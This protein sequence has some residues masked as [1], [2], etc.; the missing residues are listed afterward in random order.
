MTLYKWSKIR[1][2]SPT[3]RLE[4]VENKNAKEK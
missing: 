1:H 3:H 2:L 4:K